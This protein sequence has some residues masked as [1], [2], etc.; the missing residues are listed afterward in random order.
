MIHISFTKLIRKMLNFIDCCTVI[1]TYS[2]PQSSGN[3][4][5]SLQREIIEK[6]LGQINHLVQLI[7]LGQVRLGQVRLGQVGLCQVRLGQ[8]RLGQVRLGYVRLGQVRLG[9]VRLGQVR[10]GQVRLCQVRLGQVRLGQVMF[11]RNLYGVYLSTKQHV[12]FYQKN[13]SLTHSP[14]RKF[15]L[16]ISFNV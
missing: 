9:Q 16:K 2:F 7:R 8:V 5:L 4:N 15:L 3:E 13:V 1:L 14:L 6:K 11:L 10:L 12:I